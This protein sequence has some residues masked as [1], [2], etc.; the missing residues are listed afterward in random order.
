MLRAKP[1]SD[2]IDVVVEVGSFETKIKTKTLFLFKT[3]IKTSIFSRPVSRDQDVT[4]AF[5]R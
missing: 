5:R 1:I 2:V 4:K 3:K